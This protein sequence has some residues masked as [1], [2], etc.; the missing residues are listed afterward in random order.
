[1]SCEKIESSYQGLQGAKVSSTSFIN[2][3]CKWTL[4]QPLPYQTSANKDIDYLQIQDN[5]LFENN[6]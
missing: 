3:M 4:N 5:I 1:M 6:F 2:A